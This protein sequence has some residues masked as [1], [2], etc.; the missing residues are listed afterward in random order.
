[1]GDFFAV[2][3]DDSMGF[4]FPLS[5]I[6]LIDYAGRNPDIHYL[7]HLVIVTR[8]I[9]SAETGGAGVTGA[10]SPNIASLIGAS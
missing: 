4:L 9:D 6:I 7:S 1:V 8:P 10:P 5:V 2:Y 3:E